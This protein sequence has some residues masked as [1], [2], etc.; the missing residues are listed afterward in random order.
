MHNNKY[1]EKSIE[2]VKLALISDI[3]PSTG[4]GWVESFENNFCKFNNMQ[5]GIAVNS[6]TSGLHTALLAA[7]IGLGDE[8]I[9]PALTVVMDSFA[10]LYCGATPIFADVEI[11]TWNIDPEKV[12]KLISHKTKALITVSWFGLPSN[13]PALRQICNDYNLI[14]IDDSAEMIS[15]TGYEPSEHDAPDFRIFSFESKK[16]ISTGGEGGMILT[17]NEKFAILA[18]KFSGLGYKHL[19]ARQGRTSLASE[20]YQNPE[21]E[22]FDQVGYNYRMNPVTA[23]VGLGQLSSIDYYLNMRKIIGG[24]FYKATSQFECL[25][26]QPSIFNNLEHSYYTFGVRNTATE[27]NKNAWKDF[28]VKYKEN[29]GDGFYANCRLPTEEPFFKKLVA[30][31]KFTFTNK[32]PIA[33]LL[34]KQIMAFKTN[35]LDEFKIEEQL[36]I[37]IKTASELSL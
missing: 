29:G 17:N 16:H 35:Y 11:E 31:N 34:Q 30:E 2:N 8:V 26:P 4:L 14:L 27:K 1:S 13:L 32:F 28:Y 37:Y 33:S 6:G 12:L 18:R 3:D 25:V 22:R 9:S 36:K 24:L 10:T 19:T 5:Y 21:Y 20:I 23:A 7:G 15:S